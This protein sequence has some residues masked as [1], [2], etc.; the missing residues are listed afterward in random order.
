MYPGKPAEDETICIDQ[1]EL[2]LR[3]SVQHGCEKGRALNR[4][5]LSSLDENAEKI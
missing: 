3:G 1:A 2:C 5:F 4:F